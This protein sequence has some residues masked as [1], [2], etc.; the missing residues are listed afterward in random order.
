MHQKS[1]KPGPSLVKQTIWSVCC[2][3]G[4]G[5]ME[6]LENKWIYSHSYGGYILIEGFNPIDFN[7]VRSWTQFSKPKLQIPKALETAQS[8]SLQLEAVAL[9]V[10]SPGI[11]MDLM[12]E[13]PKNG[14]SWL[15]PWKHIPRKLGWSHVIS[16]AQLIIDPLYNDDIFWDV[17]MFEKKT[18]NR[19]PSRTCADD[20]H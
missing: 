20:D 2:F 1:P 12:N 16:P 4:M 11:G 6:N 5:L 18:S 10:W 15:Q 9:S 13:A 17:S 19:K 14:T 8:H 3:S 7:R